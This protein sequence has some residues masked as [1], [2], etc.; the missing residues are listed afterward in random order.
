MNS[1]L[2]SLLL[3]I[4]SCL[5]TATALLASA[6]FKFSDHSSISE[7][8]S[9][10]PMGFARPLNVDPKLDC[11]I[12]ELAWEFAKKLLPQVRMPIK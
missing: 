10:L 11:S 1:F 6:D 2:S 4:I 12:K 8:G 3:L 9:P 5:T 7:E